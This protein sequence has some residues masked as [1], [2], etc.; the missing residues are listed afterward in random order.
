MVSS[1]RLKHSS[2]ESAY[3]GLPILPVEWDIT[4]P[5]LCDH[6]GH[7]GAAAAPRARPG[8]RLALLHLPPLIHQKTEADH[9]AQSGLQNPQLTRRMCCAVCYNVNECPSTLC[10]IKCCFV[11]VLSYTA[12]ELPPTR[13][14]Y[15]ASLYIGR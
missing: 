15:V 6:V 3:N 5:R 11:R 10:F 12:N 7:A 9:L 1:V 13:M 4:K 14:H 2:T 8:R